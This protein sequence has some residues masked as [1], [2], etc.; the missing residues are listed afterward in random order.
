MTHPSHEFLQEALQDAT[1]TRQ[2][3]IGASVL[4]SVVEVFAQVFGDRSAVVIADEN[5]FAVAGREVQ[6]QLAADRT[7]G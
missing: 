5:T 6:R 2:V 3:V 1:D 7:R 4:P